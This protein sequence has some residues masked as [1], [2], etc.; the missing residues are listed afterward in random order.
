MCVRVRVC[1]RKSAKD[2]VMG[3]RG[4]KRGAHTHVCIVRVRPFDLAESKG[5]DRSLQF[6]HR[7]CRLLV[8]SEWVAHNRLTHSETARPADVVAVL[9]SCRE[10]HLLLLI[11]SALNTESVTVRPVPSVPCNATPHATS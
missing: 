4:K 8:E 2:N 3:C 9:S 5:K 6:E 7:L 11:T 1:E 10:P